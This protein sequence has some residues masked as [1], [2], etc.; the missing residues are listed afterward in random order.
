M[1][2]SFASS[3]S[4]IIS[5]VS[6]S[7]V[8]NLIKSQMSKFHLDKIYK[9]VLG[10]EHFGFNSYIQDFKVTQWIVITIRFNSRL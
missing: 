9:T 1:R 10:R 4:L 7:Y 8:K 5:S 6:P 2:K 3:L